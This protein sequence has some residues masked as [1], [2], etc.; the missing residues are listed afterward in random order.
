[1]IKESKPGG[2]PQ[3]KSSLSNAS[4]LKA[5]APLAGQAGQHAKADNLCSKE[6]I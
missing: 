3:R 6:F 4:T 1:L 2:A 5:Y